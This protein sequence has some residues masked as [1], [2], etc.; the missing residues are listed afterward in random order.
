MSPGSL[1]AIFGQRLTALTVS[2]TRF[3]LPTELGGTSVTFEG[4]AA[5]LLY[6]SP[7]QI[8]VQVPSALSVNTTVAVVVRSASGV[9]D[10]FGVQVMRSGLGLLTLNAS[11]CGRGAV[12][13]VAPDGALS[14][15]SPSNSVA[16]GGILALWG[17]GFGV[18]P[19]MP[20]DGQPAPV[21]PLAQDIQGI[22]FL[23][24][25]PA[26]GL[27]MSGFRSRLF[28]GKA[29][30]LVGVDQFN[31]KLPDNAPEGC[32]VAL[33]VT[34]ENS[35][36][37]PVPVSIHRGG[38][39]CVYPAPDSIAL[40]TWKSTITKGVPG[41]TEMLL[42]EFASAVGKTAPTPVAE[43]R[44]CLMRVPIPAAGPSCSWT[45]DRSLD[46]GA[47]TAQGPGFGPVQILPVMVNDRL[48]YSFALPSGTLRAGVF[49]VTGAGGR[50]VGPFTTSITLPAAIEVTSFSGAAEFL[51]D[52]GPYTVTAKWRGGD[53]ASVVRLEVDTVLSFPTQPPIYVNQ[54]AQP[55]DA[56]SITMPWGNLGSLGSPSA[57]VTQTGADPQSF[58]ASG[59]TLGGRHTWVY[60]FKLGSKA[61]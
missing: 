21:A 36:S 3:P 17:T 12:L 54:C 11:R 51:P 27:P 49:T 48:T 23:L 58:S 1:A 44:N 8:N 10:P 59:L 35:T 53:A 2:A 34:D 46:A 43:A 26:F 5:P 40:L 14:F 24:P 56:G 9:S 19:D 29:P 25:I 55:A 13:N 52:V 20:P 28:A 60:E 30:T 31:I 41:S 61:F 22:E 4:V 39:Q 32:S 57:I 7:S 18:V 38:G 6:V 16:P 37:Q 15:N 42:I 33:R 47:L 50:D 45:E